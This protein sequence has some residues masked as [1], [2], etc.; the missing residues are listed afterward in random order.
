MQKINQWIE[1]A[2]CE[3]NNCQKSIIYPI[4]GWNEF[5]KEKFEKE[6]KKLKEYLNILEKELTIKDYLVGNRLTLAD[7]ILFR[8]LFFL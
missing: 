1:F 5:S 8:F 3:I 4:F 2:T 7:I 6:N